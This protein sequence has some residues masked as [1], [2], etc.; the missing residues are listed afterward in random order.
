MG[1]NEKI[2][3][4]SQADSLEKMGEFW[5]THDFTDFDDPNRPDVQFKVSCA[6]P[7]DAELFASVEK[8]A[9]LRGISVETLVNLWVQEK[10]TE[11]A[12]DNNE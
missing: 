2:S 10:L 1:A 12:R 3:S 7:L 8:Q 5:D 4:I 6:V 11:K 9:R